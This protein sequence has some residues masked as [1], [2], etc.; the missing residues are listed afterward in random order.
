MVPAPYSYEVKDEEAEGVWGY[1]VP[2]QG[3]PGTQDTLVLK[4]RAACPLPGTSTRADGRHQVSA[5]QY[6]QEEGSIEQEKVSKGVPAG[7]YLI[8]RHN[9]CG[10]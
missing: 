7:G 2:L 8:G 3:V 1:L 5:D 6:I 4:R 9:E 10:R